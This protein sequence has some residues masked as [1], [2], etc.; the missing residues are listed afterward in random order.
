MDESP[1]LALLAPEHV[2]CMLAHEVS[3]L[4]K[5]HPIY[6]EVGGGFTATT[7]IWV[8]PFRSH[9]QHHRL[10]LH[11]SLHCA[12]TPAAHDANSCSIRLIE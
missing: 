6:E 12:V 4:L 1:R 2:E 9:A 5:G 8:T 11:V 10:L 3:V 7:C